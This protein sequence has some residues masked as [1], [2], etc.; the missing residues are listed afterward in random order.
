MISDCFGLGFW[1]FTY[2]FATVVLM[3]NGDHKALIFPLTGVV[4]SESR[5]KKNQSV[6]IDLRE[7]PGRY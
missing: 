3:W 7:C 4:L 6:V 5:K 1:L 2:V